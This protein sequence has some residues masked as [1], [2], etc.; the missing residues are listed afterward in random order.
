MGITE[1]TMATFPDHILDE[2]R[3]SANIADVVG[4]AVPLAKGWAC[5][6]FHGEKTPSFHVKPDRGVFHCFG[7]GA[8]GDVF[9]FVQKYHGDTF[10]EAVKRLAVRYGIRLPDSREDNPAQHA[11]VAPPKVRPSII[12]QRG[13]GATRVSF[14]N[15]N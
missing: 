10:P 1:K 14:K 15:P 8:G 2:I 5:C 12:D 13:T 9:A 11:T 4:D 3:T 7:C 6:P